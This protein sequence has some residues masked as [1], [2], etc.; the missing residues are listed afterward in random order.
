MVAASCSPG[1]GCFRWSAS[2]FPIYVPLWNYSLGMLAFWTNSLGM[3]LHTLQLAVLKILSSNNTDAF[4]RVNN[5]SIQSCTRLM[6]G[7]YRDLKYAL[8]TYN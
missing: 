5:V 3:L 8:R 2:D 7:L 1:S 4:N 6:V